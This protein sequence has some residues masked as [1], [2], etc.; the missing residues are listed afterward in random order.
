MP[1]EDEISDQWR[2]ML[3]GTDPSLARLRRWWRRVPSSPR[4]KVCAAPFTGPGRLLTRLIMHGR[5]SASPLLCNVCFGSLGK[6]AGGAEIEMSVLFADVRGSTALAERIPAGEFR[7]LLQDYYGVAAHAVEH[8][9]GVV[10]KF[11]GD[12]VMALFI[13]VIAGERHAGRALDAARDI[14]AHLDD[15]GLTAKGLRVGV[16]VH[17][18]TAFVGTVG[19]GE[20]LDFTALGD[21]VNVAARLGSVAQGGEVLVS[22]DAWEAAGNDGNSAPSRTIDVTGRAEP[23]EVV[24]EQL[25][26]RVGAAPH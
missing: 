7:R 17:V 6:A 14:Q 25:G 22:R 3:L 5:S 13:P 1:S 24:S 9:G 23:V 16:G 10:D 20:R 2:K 18:G 4:C 8:N 12:G 26:D 21:T 19:S 15:S 11:L